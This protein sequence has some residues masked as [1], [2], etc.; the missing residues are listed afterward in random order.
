MKRSICTV[1]AA[2]M[3]AFVF[4]TAASAETFSD[5]KADRWSY[6]DIDYAV[7]KGYLKGVGGGRF[8]PEGA[9]T[10]AMVVTVLYRV[11]GEPKVTAKSPF[12][13]VP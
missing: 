10:R 2:V 4:A 5:V 7:H 3:L 12:T 8:D 1:L 9:C 13:D 11:E 6:Q